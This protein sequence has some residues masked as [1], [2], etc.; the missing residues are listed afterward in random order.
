MAGGC[1]CWGVPRRELLWRLGRCLEP[2]ALVDDLPEVWLPALTRG[3]SLANEYALTGVSSEESPA[4]FFRHAL[5]RAQ[6]LPSV[7]LAEA[8]SGAYVRVGGQVVVRQRPGTAK[9]FSFVTLEDEWGQVNLVLRPDL[10][11]RYRR[12]LR[13][14]GLLAEGVVERDGGVVNMKVE[15]LW[16][17]LPGVH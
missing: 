6:A 17:L 12:E 13:A 16:P 9:G 1:D 5:T 15:R 7:C 3:E 2:P 14:P 4:V 11:P 8:P 10:Y